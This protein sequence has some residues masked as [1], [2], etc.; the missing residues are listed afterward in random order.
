MQR[1]RGLALTTALLTTFAA[2][3]D[4]GPSRRASEGDNAVSEAAGALPAND[5]RVAGLNLDGEPARGPVDA[6]VYVV[7]FTDYECEFCARQHEVVAGELMRLNGGRLRHVVRNFPMQAAHPMA[8]RAAEAAECAA[9]QGHFWEFHTALFADR[10]GL[11]APDLARRAQRAGL[12]EDRFT[13]CLD[14]GEATAAVRAD[15]EQAREAG[16]RGTPTFFV[17]GRRLEGFQTLEA[18]A[19]AVTQALQGGAGGDSPPT[20]I[21]VRPGPAANGGG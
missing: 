10:G 12:N 3:C 16:V 6:P 2:A 21:A 13:H 7:E 4:S 9:R 14:K 20:S 19:A 1:V 18:L 8:F 5:A 11:H 17:N 15:L